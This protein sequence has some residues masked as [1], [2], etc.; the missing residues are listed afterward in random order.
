MTQ[1]GNGLFILGATLSI[2]HWSVLKSYNGCKK[3]CRRENLAFWRN[4]RPSCCT[5]KMTSSETW[6]L[7]AQRIRSFFGHTIP[8]NVNCNAAIGKKQWK[9]MMLMWYGY[10]TI[11][12]TKLVLAY[13]TVQPAAHGRTQC[14]L[15]WVTVSTECRCC[16]LAWRWVSCSMFEV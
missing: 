3:W 12:S 14:L 5:A 1:A 10:A 11:I 2:I 8:G 4:G 15:R 13:P 7:Q 9:T 6:H 16:Q